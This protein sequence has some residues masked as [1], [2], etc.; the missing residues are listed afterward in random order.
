MNIAA[1][2]NATLVP[3]ITITPN[4]PLPGGGIT[5]M[6]I[7]YSTLAGIMS[8]KNV[9]TNQYLTLTTSASPSLTT[10]S[11]I[12]NPY[13]RWA[14]QYDSDWGYIVSNF[15][16]I[17]NTYFGKKVGQNTL[18]IGAKSTINYLLG[19]NIISSANST[20][21]IGDN[22]QEITS[23]GSLM[24]KSWSLSNIGINV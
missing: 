5:V 22:A 24:T 2:A 1:T 16:D 11:S 3:G 14:V 13:S 21:S 18:S 9:S 7:S 8:F 23:N 6:A 10:S 20:V 4:D 19:V 12:V 15:S 17:H